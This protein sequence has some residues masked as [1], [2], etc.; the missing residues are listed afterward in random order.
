MHG[1]E[2]LLTGDYVLTTTEAATELGIQPGSVKRLCQR[3]ILKGEKRGRDWFISK[4]EVERYKRDRRAAGRPATVRKAKPMNFQDA[5]T[6]LA[7]R[8]GD[9][10]EARSVVTRAVLEIVGGRDDDGALG[11]WIAAG[12]YSGNETA[13]SIAAEW[14]E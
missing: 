1:D 12:E 7:T 9:I 6:I 5:I 13:E 8:S 2:S 10:D 3:E 4:D 14:S 11:D